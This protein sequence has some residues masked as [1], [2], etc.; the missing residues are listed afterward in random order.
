MQ[1]ALRGEVEVRLAA[2]Y[3]DIERDLLSGRAQVAWAPPLVS[4]RIESYGGRLLARA[5]RHG[6]GTY[7]SALLERRGARV[8]IQPA[9]NLRAAWVDRRS[10][11]G[12][13]LPQVLL[14]SLGLSSWEV[15]SQERF[16][17]SY[18]RAREELLAGRVDV[19]SA[20]VHSA[21]PHG[22]ARE[23]G[24][25]VSILGVSD[26]CTN[27]GIV[28]GPGLASGDAQRVCEAMLG[29]H[30]QAGDLFAEVFEADRFEAAP[31]GTFR[32][33]YRLL[34]ASLPG[35]GRSLG[36]RSAGAVVLRPNERA[37]VESS[38]S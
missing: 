34:I 37:T 36:F 8:A 33:V 16:V 32:E 25:E 38:G 14:H 19:C 1:A 17:G 22:V 30:L 27:D 10:M 7:R 24:T 28:V 20:A 4:A 31:A 23:M 3:D 13:V 2:S 21:S 18:A 35:Q 6:T 15:F 12:Y 26:P 9:A 29:L 11:G 5:V